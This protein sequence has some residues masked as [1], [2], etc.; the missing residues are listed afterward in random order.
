MCQGLFIP[1]IKTRCAF[2]L[3]SP[4]SSNLPEST[5]KTPL[6]TT[7]RPCLTPT[8]L[9]VPWPQPRQRPRGVGSPDQ[10]QSCLNRCTVHNCFIYVLIQLDFVITL[11]SIWLIFYISLLSGKK[12]PSPTS[13]PLKT[14][15]PGFQLWLGNLTTLHL[16]WLPYTGYLLLLE[17][18]LILLITYPERPCSDLLNRSFIALFNFV[19][20][21]PCCSKV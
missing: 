1:F 5:L 6:F 2:L 8:S 10:P 20:Y 9:T 18:I 3:R 7:L 17:L 11:I 4:F 19:R 15:L 21:I 13:S 12:N 16:S 14:L